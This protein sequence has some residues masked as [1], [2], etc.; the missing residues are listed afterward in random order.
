MESII[1][2]LKSGGVE[3]FILSILVLFLTE[4]IKIPIKKYA[5]K[6]VIPEK[7]TRF[8]PIIPFVLG[9]L[10]SMVVVSW[11]QG[12]IDLND[13]FFDLWLSASGLS[14]AFYSCYE[15]FRD[16][17]NVTFEDVFQTAVYGL[18]KEKL[19]KEPAATLKQLTETAVEI[20]RQ[21]KNGQSS[22]DFYEE[23]QELLKNYLDTTEAGA[24]AKRVEK[25]WAELYGNNSYTEE[26]ETVACTATEK[27][28]YEVRKSHSVKKTNMEENKDKEEI[29]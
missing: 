21:E 14:I 2:F 26:V 1:K 6:R 13:E 4:L 19:G 17:G 20:F 18:L 10:L 5:R 29:K 16:S 9:G 25:I 22:V 12:M 27:Y 11:E 28:E 24:I 3:A 23:M 15:N 7:I 8:I